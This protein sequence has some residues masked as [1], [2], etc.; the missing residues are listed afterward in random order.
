MTANATSPRPP[1]RGRP[2]RHAVDSISCMV[3]L[4][5]WAVLQIDSTGQSRQ[6][7]ICAIVVDHLA[8]PAHNAPNEPSPHGDAAG[9]S[10]DPQPATIP[11]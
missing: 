3:R 2:R 11:Q 4:P 10:G 5:S 1:F 6:D 8:S 7:A 9:A